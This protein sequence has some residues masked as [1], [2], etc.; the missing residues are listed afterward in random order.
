MKAFVLRWL[1]N[2]GVLLVVAQQYTALG[3]DGHRAFEVSGFMPAL[4]AVVMITLANVLLHPIGEVV[5]ALGCIFNVVTLGLF[6]WA[7][8]FAFYTFA[9]Y[10]VGTL[11]PLGG[12]HVAGLKEAAFGAFW[13]SVANALLTPLLRRSDDRRG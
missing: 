8:S 13:M 2:A 11:D 10:L 5:T 9:F 3:P 7:V 4:G 1:V 6:G 12:F